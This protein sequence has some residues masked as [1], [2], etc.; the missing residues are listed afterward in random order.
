MV[1]SAVWWMARETSCSHP[2]GTDSPS[3]L[4]SEQYFQ[5]YLLSLISTD[6]EQLVKLTQFTDHRHSNVRVRTYRAILPD[7]D[8]FL[9]FTK[10]QTSAVQM[11][12]TAQCNDSVA[13]CFMRSNF[14]SLCSLVAYQYASDVQCSKFSRHPKVM[15]VAKG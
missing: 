7:Y 15:I 13:W 5:G 1:I 14:T 4:A 6:L 9:E 12:M 11:Q 8:G 2:R 3:S 10:C